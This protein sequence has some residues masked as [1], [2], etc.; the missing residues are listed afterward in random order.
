MNNNTE[1]QKVNFDQAKLVKELGFEWKCDEW[2]HSE[3]ETRQ[4]DLLAPRVIAYPGAKQ[5]VYAELNGVYLKPTI[6]L[7]FKWIRDV[8]GIYVDIMSMDKDQ[9]Y[10][11]IMDSRNRKLLFESEWH[12]AIYET[13]ER[14]ALDEALKHLASM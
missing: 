7:V 14:T 13:A 9:W 6:Q 11:T 3:T 12:Y 5:L 2:F 4:G 8:H 10:I 1:L